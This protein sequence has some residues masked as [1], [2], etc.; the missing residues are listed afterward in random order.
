[1]TIVPTV[2]TGS[3]PAAGAAAPRGAGGAA[4]AQ[5][6]TIANPTIHPHPRHARA[7]IRSRLRRA[8]AFLTATH[9]VPRVRLLMSD[10]SLV[11]SLEPPLW[12]PAPTPGVVAAFTTRQGGVSLP[13]YHA[14][15]LGRSTADQPDAVAANRARVLTALG[16]DPERLATAGQVH[17][18][19]V[20]RVG[21]PGLHRECDALVT[22]TPG[23]PL[24]VSAADCLPIL[25]VAPGAVAAAHA[26]WRGTAAGIPVSALDAVCEVAGVGAAE[27]SV[28][29]GPCIRSCCYEVGPEVAARFPG[30][31]VSR[32][33]DSIRLSIPDAVRLQ[34]LERGVLPGRLFDTG[35]CT[36][37]EEFW[38]Y[39]H[40][41]D[42]GV[43]GRQWGLIALA[44]GGGDTPHRPP[45]GHEV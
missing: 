26:G 30:M 41:R 19:A 21:G 25:Y 45:S 20:T 27:V 8:S 10:W 1:M 22:R 28:H 33:G 29:L 3:S 32:R 38:Y 14:L 40:R 24:A 2:A 17:G 4:H 18:N 31:A 42:R 9:A 6:V 36:A 35:A 39:S 44:D 13:P 7:I 11:R 12:R 43:T 34:L 15:N 5:A 37:C 23:I 16:L